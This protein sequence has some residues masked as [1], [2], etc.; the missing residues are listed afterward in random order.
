M[1]A[2]LEFF[3]FLLSKK[4]VTF[5]ELSS[6]LEIDERLWLN[7]L[8]SFIHDHVAVKFKKLVAAVLKSSDKMYVCK[9]DK[10]SF[11]KSKITLITQ[12]FK[13]LLSLDDETLVFHLET[14]ET[15]SFKFIEFA[16]QIILLPM[17][18]QL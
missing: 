6:K 3:E 1:T 2:Q 15:T 10:E 7:N 12:L 13:Y 5:E 4:L 17:I 8:H 9:E 14:L 18:H 16:I 11:T